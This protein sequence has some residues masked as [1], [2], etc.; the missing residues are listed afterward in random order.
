MSVGRNGFA[1]ASDPAIANTSP[2]IKQRITSTTPN[3]RLVT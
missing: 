2:A 1:T 3:P